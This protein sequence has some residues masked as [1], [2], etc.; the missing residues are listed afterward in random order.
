MSEQN[1]TVWGVGLNDDVLHGTYGSLIKAERCARAL[2]AEHGDALEIR[3]YCALVACVRP[4]AL[5]RVWTDV[6]DCCVL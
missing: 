4:D 2:V 3:H 5:G 6:V 1:W